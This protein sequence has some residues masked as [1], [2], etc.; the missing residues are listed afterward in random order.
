MLSTQLIILNYPEKYRVAQ[1]KLQTCKF[2][3]PLT[4]GII[5]N[6]KVLKIIE[7]KVYTTKKYYENLL[8]LLMEKTKLSP[9]LGPL[10]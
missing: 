8:T 3:F 1:F 6:D 2:Y 4:L 9:I 7:N 10:D 5:M